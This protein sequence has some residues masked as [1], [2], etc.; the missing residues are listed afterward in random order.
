M[1]IATGTTF[2]ASTLVLGKFPSIF[3]KSCK[4]LTHY[5]FLAQGRIAFKNLVPLQQSGPSQLQQH[6]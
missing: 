3:L 1:K 5:S 6:T 4:L 2:I